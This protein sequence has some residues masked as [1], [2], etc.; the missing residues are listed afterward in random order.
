MK[1]GEI[2]S[3]LRGKFITFEGIEGS[4]KSVQCRL[5]AAALR[6]AGVPVVLLREPGSTVIGE[7]IRRIL[8]DR[9]NGDLR[10]GAEL[11]LYLASRAQL[12]EET[13]LPALKAGKTVIGDRFQDASRAY[14]GWGTGVDRIFIEAGGRFAVRGREP[15]LTILLDLDVKT[16]LRRSGRTDRIEKKSFVFHRRVRQGYLALARAH[17]DRIKTIAVKKQGVT[18]IQAQVR[19]IVFRNF[20]I[21]A[22]QN[23]TS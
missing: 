3:K 18:E 23:R 17:P 6:K 16:G 1:I 10:P 11:L 13:I 19:Q 8:L 4:G 2:Q 9:K 15:D 12:V 14:Q 22:S 21:H 5:L 7:K 20:G